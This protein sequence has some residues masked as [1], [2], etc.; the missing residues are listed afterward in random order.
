ML[1][2]FCFDRLAVTVRDMYFID[3]DPI[4]G[5]EGAERGVRVEL[6]LVEPQPW[7][8]SIYAAQKLVVD[9]ALLRVDL[10]ESIERGPGSKDRMHHHPTMA[11]NEPG[12]RVFDEAIVAEPLGWLRER[13]ADP[14]ALLAA[15]GVPGLA[16]YEE[17]AAELTASLPYVVEAVGTNLD[18][19]RAGELA[20]T[21]TRGT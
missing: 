4:P 8:G 5:Q 11:D 12:D 19:V 13:L 1:S 6:R 16:D 18:R 21:R 10:F 3:P 2:V 7:R 20:L 17:S 14:L 9:T 15:A